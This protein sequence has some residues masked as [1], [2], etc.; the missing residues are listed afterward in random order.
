MK[1]VLFLVLSSVC[2]SATVL[3]HTVQSLNSLEQRLECRADAFGIESLTQLSRKSDS[4]GQIHI[5]YTNGLDEVKRVLLEDIQNLENQD[6][7][8]ANDGELNLSLKKKSDKYFLK[9]TG[10]GYN[11]TKEIF[12]S[13]N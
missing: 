5:Q 8:I 3:A 12:C 4:L 10:D 7:W 2:S 6:L 9:I 13:K 1:S 11:Q